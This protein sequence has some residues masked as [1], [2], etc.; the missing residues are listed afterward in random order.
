MRFLGLVLGLAFGVLAVPAA[1]I[2]TTGAGSAVA[3]VNGS[4]GMRRAFR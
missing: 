4:W 2:Q 3:V 1:V